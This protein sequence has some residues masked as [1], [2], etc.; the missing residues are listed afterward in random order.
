MIST[1]PT[2]RI[3][4]QDCGSENIRAEVSPDGT[5]FGYECEVCG[6][7]SGVLEHL[8]DGGWRRV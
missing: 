7:G 2:D 5:F 1:S 3:V 6:G 8:E 4:C